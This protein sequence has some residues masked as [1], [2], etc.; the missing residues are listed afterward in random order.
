MRAAFN[1]MT[2]RQQAMLAASVLVFGFLLGL[3]TDPHGLRRWWAMGGE[4][5]R[6]GSENARLRTEVD[7]LKRR[8]HALQNDD[9]ALER[10]A[11]ENGYVRADEILFELR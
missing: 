11:R 2:L 5:D 3:V 6:L 10:V 1:A 7:A 8:A 9:Q 4:I